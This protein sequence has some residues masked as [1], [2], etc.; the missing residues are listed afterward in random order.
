M[1]LSLSHNKLRVLGPAL[2]KCYSLTELRLSH[3]RIK[4]RVLSKSE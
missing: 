2:K 1:Q 4:V 3:N